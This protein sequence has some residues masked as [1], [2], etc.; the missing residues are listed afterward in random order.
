MSYIRRIVSTFVVG[1]I[2]LMALQPVYAQTSKPTANG[3]RISP[4]RNEVTIEKGKSETVSIMV[5]NPSGLPL[6]AKAVVND[7]VASESEDGQPKILLD[8]EFAPSHS[9]KKLIQDVPAFDVAA[10][11]RKEVKVTITIPSGA[12]AGGYYGAIRFLP[13]DTAK[14]GANVALTASVGSIFLVNVP[15]NI[16][17][18]LEL[19]QFG[20]AV[21]GKIKKIIVSGPV[22]IITRLKNDGDTH[23]KP[24]GKI[25]VKDSKG[26][27]VAVQEINNSEPQANVLPSSI[28]KFETILTN[29]KWFGHYTVTASYGYTPSNGA[30]INAKTSFWFIPVWMLVVGAILLLA[31]LIGSYMIYKKIQ[32]K[33]KKL[34]R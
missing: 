3:F 20:A 8:N 6:K 9:L 29:K 16:R 34:H 1:L 7:F 17:E 31:I 14:N 27:V 32:V 28:R 26:K 33:R 22:S 21:D 18:H 12:A 25:Q 11:E 5:E 15:G 19:V 13:E 24:Y 23:E 10:N 2:A 30:L 4:V